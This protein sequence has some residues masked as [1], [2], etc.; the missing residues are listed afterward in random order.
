MVSIWSAI[1]MQKTI[2]KKKKPLAGDYICQKK[3][4]Y[5]QC[6]YGDKKKKGA[7]SGECKKKTETD[8][9]WLSGR[10]N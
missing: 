3:K 6:K 8:L 5:L 9:P 4:P 7:I 10:F 2:K 1:G